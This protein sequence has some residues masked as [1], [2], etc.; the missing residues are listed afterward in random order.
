MDLDP[1]L[2]DMI[3]DYVSDALEVTGTRKALR[4]S[5]TQPTQ[6]VSEPEPE[7][8]DLEP[9]TEPF[10]IALAAGEIARAHVIDERNA[11]AALL[12]QVAQ[13]LAHSESAVDPLSRTR[14]ARG[15]LE[16]DDEVTNILQRPE[17]KPEPEPE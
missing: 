5:P 2:L 11:D 12:G 10:G 13:Q 15:T 6:L 14:A 1:S 8:E 16:I 7:P 3:D 4:P 9:Q 17:P